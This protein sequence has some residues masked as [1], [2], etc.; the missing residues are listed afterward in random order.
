MAT[1]ANI[2]NYLTDNAAT[3]RVLTHPPLFTAQD[4][5]R[6]HHVVK[7][8]VADHAVYRADYRFVLAVV[9]AG[10]TINEPNL[11]HVLQARDIVKASDWDIE[12]L[13]PGCELGAAPLLGNL[14]GLTVVADSAFEKRGRIVFHV[15]SRATSIMMS[16]RDYKNAADPIV[17]AI[18][19]PGLSDHHK[20]VTAESFA[21][22][23]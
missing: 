9:P 4:L 23:A 21:E 3:F 18:A 13:F 20:E 5:A 10:S 1:Q 19:G 7:D 8:E 11:R 17:A 6:A 12:R 15:C 16:W 2:F 14:F 22:P